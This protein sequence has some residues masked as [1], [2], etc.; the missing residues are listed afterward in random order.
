MDEAYE[1]MPFD[2]PE[3]KSLVERLLNIDLQDKKNA[4][5]H[6]LLFAIGK[7]VYGFLIRFLTSLKL[8]VQKTFFNILLIT[9]V[10]LMFV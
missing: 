1:F 4:K 7:R 9:G 6:N 2:M 5:L 3:D 8:M 10:V